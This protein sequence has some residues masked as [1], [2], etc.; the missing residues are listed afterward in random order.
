MKGEPG[1]SPIYRLGRQSVSEAD[2]Q[3]R[4][5]RYRAHLWHNG[6]L[7]V[8]RP[9]EVTDDWIRQALIG[10]AEKAYGRRA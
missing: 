6:G 4:L 7:I 5:H 1:I 3:D 10:E 9:E 8:L 2:R